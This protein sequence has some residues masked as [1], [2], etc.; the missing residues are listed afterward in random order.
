MHRLGK[1]RRELISLVRERNRN[2]RSLVKGQLSMIQET[3]RG[4]RKCVSTS[5][6]RTN[7]PGKRVL[8]DQRKLGVGWWSDL[9]RNSRNSRTL[10]STHLMP[11]R[12][13]ITCSKAVT[14]IAPHAGKFMH[15]T[16]IRLPWQCHTS[17][18]LSCLLHPKDRFIHSTP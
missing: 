13:A 12:L 3:I 15:E 10:N 14:E 1:R 8:L 7:L 2:Q 18:S 16:T 6:Y 5:H 17:E 4:E 11:R 9:D